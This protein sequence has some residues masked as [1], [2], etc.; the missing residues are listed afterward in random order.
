MNKKQR[1]IQYIQDRLK[2]YKKLE[3]ELLYYDNKQRNLKSISYDTVRTS[4]NKKDMNISYISKIN[5]IK[6]NMAKISHFIDK[7]FNGKYRLVLWYRYI[8]GLSLKEIA[9]AMRCSITTIKRFE[10]QA[11]EKFIDE[12]LNNKK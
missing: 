11:L 5:D 8:D 1:Q 3:D 12:N 10:I 7:H 2:Q 9:E 6:K 4:N